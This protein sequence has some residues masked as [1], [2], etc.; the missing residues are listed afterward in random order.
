[1]TRPLVS[2]VVPVYFNAESLP[3]LGERLRAIAAA[4]D[5]DMEVVFVDDGSGDQ[6]WDLIQEI[7]RGW[8]AARG[9][10]L[11]RNFG[12]QMAVVAGLREARG[13]A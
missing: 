5:F 13:D 1:M 6:S 3:R 8:S 10:R 9:I 11:T 4:A 7:A 12:S 2:V